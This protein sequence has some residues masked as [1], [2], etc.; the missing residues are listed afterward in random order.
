MNGIIRKKIHRYDVR[1]VEWWRTKSGA[2][3]LTVDPF[4]E[5]R[6]NELFRA[7]MHY[8]SLYEEIVHRGRA[9]VNRF[10]IEVVDNGMK[11]I[12]F[13]FPIP[14]EDVKALHKLTT[15]AQFLKVVAA[16]NHIRKLMD[17]KIPAPKKKPAPPKRKSVP[18][19]QAAP[20][21]RKSTPRKKKAPK[22]IRGCAKRTPPCPGGCVQVRSYCR[23]LPN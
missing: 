10:A 6:S 4:E 7:C 12:S 8:W 20:P 17:I 14:N 18:K 22:K 2:L 19:K 9:D 15:Q 3:K 11:A 23:R 1:G 21:K 13:L 16:N 5:K